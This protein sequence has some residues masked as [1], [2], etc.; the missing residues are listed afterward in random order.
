V[1]VFVNASQLTLLVAMASVT[2]ISAVVMTRSIQ[3]EDAASSWVWAGV[4]A[5]ASLLTAW[6][7]WRLM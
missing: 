1:S 6:S 2:G 7:F 5:M 3:E 4:Y